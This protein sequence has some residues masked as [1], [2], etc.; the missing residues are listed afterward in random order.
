VNR[1]ADAALVDEAL[2]VVDD[3]RRKAPREFVLALSA[4][5]GSLALVLLAGAALSGGAVR[6]LL[7]NLAS[8]VIGAWLTVVLIDGLWKRMQTGA[9][10]SLDR[11]S[12][13]LEARRDAPL[14]DDERDAWRTFV[15]EYSELE[16]SKSPLDRARAVPRYGSHLRELEA[17]GNRTLEAF[18]P[19]NR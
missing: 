19:K 13:D 1:S 8:E 15:R 11:M 7:L 16:R 18:D 17:H 4:I 5:L 3:A 14:T 10:A 12:T 9:S 2:A 6:D